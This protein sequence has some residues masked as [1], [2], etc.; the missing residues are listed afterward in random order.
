[1][2]KIIISVLCICF[3]NCSF[4]QFNTFIKNFKKCSLPFIVTDVTFD[5]Y[6][7]EDDRY[8]ISEEDCVKYLTM[9][10]DTVINL[11]EFSAPIGYHKYIAIGKFDV[12]DNFLGVLYYRYLIDKEENHI[13]E[14]MLCVF[15]KKGELMSTY[16]ISGF[17]MAKNK[18]FYSTIF[19]EENIEILFYNLGT[20]DFITE[21][22]IEKKNLYITKEG[23]IQN[24]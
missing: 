22:V 5:M 8:V 12:Y 17:Y 10:N 2:K 4:G 18:V 6:H 9:K 1:M 20:Y 16:P 19:S 24:K 15:T 23:F 14:L 3:F 13:Q 21:N 11:K 7:S